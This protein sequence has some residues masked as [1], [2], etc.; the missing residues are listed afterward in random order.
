MDR[1]SFLLAAAAMPFAVAPLEAEAATRFDNAIASAQSKGAGSI[2]V[3]VN[4][5]LPPTAGSQ[6]QGF[7]IKSSTKTFGEGLVLATGLPL[8][9]RVVDLL[10]G[11]A[12]VPA[13]NTAWRSM[14]TVEMLLTHTGGLEKNR[15]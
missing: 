11:F 4:G 12:N 14:V 13:S 7:D 3:L 10:P 8:N 6:T 2:R 9:A 1:R 5:Q 15:G